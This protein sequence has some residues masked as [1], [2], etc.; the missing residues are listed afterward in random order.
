[1]RHILTFINRRLILNFIVSIVSDSPMQKK[2]LFHKNICFQNNKCNKNKYIL[3]VDN[4]FIFK[5]ITLTEQ[6]QTTNIWL[7]WVLTFC[8]FGSWIDVIVIHRCHRYHIDCCY[9][10]G[11][12]ASFPIDEQWKFNP[13]CFGI[14]ANNN[15]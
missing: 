9:L 13:K 3:L 12:F 5:S 1:M 4:K 10:I 6:Q 8:P 2:F 11:S 7:Y 15:Q 14:N